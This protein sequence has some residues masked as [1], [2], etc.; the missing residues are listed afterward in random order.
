MK[1]KL[2][3]K[4]KKDAYTIGVFYVNGIRFSE[5]L[6]D[7]DRGLNSGMS[8]EEIKSKKV[9]GQTAIPTGIYKIALTHSPKF[10]SRAWAKKY[11]GQVPQIMGVKG[12]DGVRIHPFNTAEECLGC[13]AVGDNKEKGKVL[14]ATKRF[15][16]LMDKYI[17]PAVSRGEGIT[18]TIK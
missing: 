10:A 15:Y 7:P 4:Y 18:L 8:L 16:E 9:Y 6:E 17:M 14:N 13:I 11:G 1:L 2:D 12:F 3:R 5:C